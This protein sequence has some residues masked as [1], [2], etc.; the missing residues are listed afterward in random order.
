MNKVY[1]IIGPPASGKT[2]IVKKLREYGIPVLISHTTRPPKPDE[3]DGVDYYFV[4]KQTFEKMNFIEM[5]NYAEQLYG[6]TKEEV[7]KKA[8]I[9]PVSVV[10]I[11][12]SGFEK[13]K[14]LLG[15]RLELIYNFVDQDT[16]INRYLLQGE[17]YATIKHRIEYAEANGEFNNWEVADYVVKNSGP[18]I[19]T[20]RQILAIMDLVSLKIPE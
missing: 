14:K 20:V 4:D 1:A 19:V 11:D 18:L 8:N 12:L 10:D 13:L 7:L 5:V 9:H 3:K 2:S 15:D 16:I 17:D 6:L